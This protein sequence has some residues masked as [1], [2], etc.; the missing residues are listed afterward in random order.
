MFEDRRRDHLAFPSVCADGGRHNRG[1]ALAK[2]QEGLRTLQTMHSKRKPWRGQVPILIDCEIAEALSLG[3]FGGKGSLPIR[4]RL[5]SRV[6]GVSGT[7]ALGVL[8]VG[9]YKKPPGISDPG[10]LGCSFTSGAHQVPPLPKNEG[11]EI[12]RRGSS[13][14]TRSSAAVGAPSTR[15]Q[16]CRTS[17]VGAGRSGGFDRGRGFG[18]F[19]IRASGMGLRIPCFGRT[20]KAQCQLVCRELSGLAVALETLE[21]PVNPICSGSHSRFMRL[22]RTD[23]GWV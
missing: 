11:K 21:N 12:Q 6:V 14:P 7:V 22:F 4:A 10:L 2:R 1:P 13:R 9:L 5:S 16:G 23:A 15:W 18:G 8:K 17:K 3:A 19:G 20:R